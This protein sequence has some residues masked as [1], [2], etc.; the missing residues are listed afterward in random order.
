MG[1]FKTVSDFEQ[2]LKKHTDLCMLREHWSKVTKEEGKILFNKEKKENKKATLK[3]N[4]IDAKQQYLDEINYF[5]ES[6]FVP[7]S[8]TFLG[9]R[10]KAHAWAIADA[11]KH[12]DK[13]RCINESV[14]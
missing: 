14:D 1:K 2:Y 8:M 6:D 12:F 5:L 9:Y 10:R 7:S 4:V 3:Q 11:I 13:M